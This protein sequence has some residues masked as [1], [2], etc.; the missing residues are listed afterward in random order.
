MKNNWIFALLLVFFSA[1]LKSFAYYE[2]TKECETAL[3]EILDLHLQNATKIINEEKLKTPDNYFLLYL[4]NYK[5]LVEILVHED[6]SSYKAYLEKFN[7]RLDK[8]EEK[9]PST[10]Y[11]RALRAEM[12]AQTGLINVLNGDE[13]SGFIKIVKANK[14]LKVNFKENPDFYLN[15]KLYGVFNVVFDNIPPV[16]KWATTLLGLVG[17]TEDGFN[18]LRSYKTEMEGRPGLYSESLVYL[19]FAYRIVSDDQGAYEMLKRDYVPSISTTLG[20]YLYALVLYRNGKNDESLDLLYTLNSDE[21]EVPFYPIIQLIAREKLNRLD[22]DSE[23]YWLQYLN[24]SKNENYKK[25]SCNMLSY[26]YLLND[27]EEKYIFYRNMV[28]TY[29]KAIINEDREA[30]VEINRPY[31]VNIDLLKAHFLVSGSYFDKADS[32]LGNYNPDEN[33]PIPAYEIQY[34]LLKGKISSKTGSYKETMALYKLAIDKGRKLKEHY[35]AEA[36]LMAG[37]LA[38]ENEHFDEAHDYYKLSQSI[39]C[40]N[41]IYRETIRKNAKTRLRKLRYLYPQP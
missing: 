1:P 21:M 33:N 36:A 2:I 5:D 15:K 3:M 25:E 14:L 40:D 34:Y 12:M 39:N 41:N 35:A 23:V 16:V 4:E 30:D 32:V 22:V 28:S 18:Y 29:D 24:N 27:N 10:P 8:M 38:N 20:T 9:N 37:I 13:V 7:A 19:T 6:K 26:Y 31:P 17:S 11:Y